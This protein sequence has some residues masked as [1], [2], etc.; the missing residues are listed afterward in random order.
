M[1]FADDLNAYRI[2]GAKIENSTIE[3]NLKTC[4]QELHRWGAANQVAFDAAKESHH[5]LSPSDPM[6]SGFKLLGISFD[7]ELTMSEAVAEMV[8]AAGWKLRTLLRT[9]RFYN[10]AELIILFKAHLLSFLEYRTP[11]VYHATRSVL[12]RL[13]AVQSRFL[14]DVGVDDVTAV[15]E[16]R[17]A[18]LA[19][20]RD[21]AMLGLIHR[22][23][24]GKGPKEFAEHFK[25]QDNTFMH[26]PRRDYKAAII[27][28][29]ALGLVAIYNMLPREIVAAKSVQLFQRELQSMVSKCA[30]SGHPQWQELLSPRLALETHPLVSFF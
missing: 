28:R 11:A 23:T 7:E 3:K 4:Q 19:V 6:G 22:T 9:R 24:L 10:D 5:I 26:D 25:R 29:S 18:P 16:F 17:L 8:S 21:I 12:S 20:R 14:R 1:A 2:F 13:D 27:K 15:A 30:Q